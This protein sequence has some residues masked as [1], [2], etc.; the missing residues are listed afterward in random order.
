MYK[1][2]RIVIGKGDQKVIHEHS[3]HYDFHVAKRECLKETNKFKQHSFAAFKSG[4]VSFDVISEEELHEIFTSDSRRSLSRGVEIARSYGRQ[5][6]DTGMGVM[7]GALAGAGAGAIAGIPVGAPGPVAAVGAAVGA[8]KG[9][10]WFSD[11]EHNYRKDTR[12]NWKIDDHIRKKYGVDGIHGLKLLDQKEIAS[13]YPVGSKVKVDTGDNFPSRVT[14]RVMGWD[15]S[16]EH[17]LSLKAD[18]DDQVYTG[19]HSHR[20]IGH[21]SRYFDHDKSYDDYKSLKP[22][23]LT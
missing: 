8:I 5:A 21:G 18:G 14:A 19:F 12:K 23:V 17:G 22:E 2:V 16:R 11:I 1:V 15:H 10:H 7:S 3:S 9:G 6:A 13:R 4:R 20:I